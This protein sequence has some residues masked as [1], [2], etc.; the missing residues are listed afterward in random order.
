MRKSV[1]LLIPILFSLTWL[2]GQ[3]SSSFETRYYAKDNTT[4]GITDFK[5]ETAYFNTEQRVD[6][7]AHY[8]QTAS[9]WF[10]DSALNNK[11]NETE[12]ISRF[13]DHLKEQ[14]LPEKRKRIRL[15][16]WKKKGFRLW[17]EHCSWNIPG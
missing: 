6:F 13:L 10:L 15:E 12:E 1:I 4:R 8:A 17:T 3:I 2:N 9:T 16:E 5:G 11:V 14:P 7:L